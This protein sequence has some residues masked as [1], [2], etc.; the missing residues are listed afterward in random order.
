ME[1]HAESKTQESIS[2]LALDETES[3]SPSESEYVATMFADLED[4]SLSLSLPL[5]HF[6]QSHLKCPIFCHL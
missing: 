3:V 4:P 2:L 5:F 6:G 1:K